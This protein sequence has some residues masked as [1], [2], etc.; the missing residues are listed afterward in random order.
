M[1]L[2]NVTPPGRWMF[3]P[4]QRSVQNPPRK[5][6]GRGTEGRFSREVAGG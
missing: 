4:F 5:Q 1:T 6:P 2:I 3:R